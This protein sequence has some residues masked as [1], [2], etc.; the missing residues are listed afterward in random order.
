MIKLPSSEPPHNP[1][2]ASEAS[3]RPRRTTPMKG[4]LYPN[5]FRTGYDLHKSTHNHN[6]LNTL[7]RKVGEGRSSPLSIFADHRFIVP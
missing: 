4:I 2:R 6:A 5:P 7:V 1:T 3:R